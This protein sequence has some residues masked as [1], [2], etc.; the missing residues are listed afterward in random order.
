MSGTA[1]TSRRG[2]S[3]RNPS[4]KADASV[5]E[6]GRGLRFLARSLARVVAVKSSAP[7]RD[8]H[9]ERSGHAGMEPGPTW[10]CTDGRRVGQQAR[11]P[12]QK[13]KKKK[14]GMP[15]ALAQF[16]SRRRWQ[17]T[18][19]D[20][21]AGATSRLDTHDPPKS[22]RG[23][24]IGTK[25]K[26]E[27][28]LYCV[29]LTY[30]GLPLG[31]LS[32]SLSRLGLRAPS[33]RVESC[34]TCLHRRLISIALLGRGHQQASCPTTPAP[35]LGKAYMS[36]SKCAMH[37]VTVFQTMVSVKCMLRWGHGR[38]RLVTHRGC[39]RRHRSRSR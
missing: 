7:R 18:F 28:D 2:T 27:S 24:S 39:G 36:A 12:L 34:S 11:T 30:R 5:C 38:L 14:R 17:G 10:Y 13:K 23:S 22:K 9:T 6:R 32:F 26:A 4:G 19:A 25:A 16:V 20:P 21:A 3:E 33:S 37:P 1:C 35:S 29:A 8:G 15:L 31:S